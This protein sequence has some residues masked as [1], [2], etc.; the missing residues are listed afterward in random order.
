MNLKSG[1]RNLIYFVFRQQIL[2]IGTVELFWRNL[3][4]VIL[5]EMWHAQCICYLACEGRETS[6]EIQKL[7]QQGPT[8]HPPREMLLSARE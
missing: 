8:P 2:P 5:Q 4:E 1:K 3:L 7:P 6:K